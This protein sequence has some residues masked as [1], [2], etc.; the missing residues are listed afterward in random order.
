MSKLTSILT[1]STIVVYF[2]A[3][4]EENWGAGVLFIFKKEVKKGGRNIMLN[5]NAAPLFSQGSSIGKYS[6]VML[7]LFFFRG[8]ALILK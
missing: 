2:K 6:I 8:A 7:P 4:K 5:S 1:V 3:F